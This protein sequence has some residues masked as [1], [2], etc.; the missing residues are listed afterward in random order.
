MIIL[1]PTQQLKDPKHPVYGMVVSSSIPRPGPDY[2][3]MPNKQ[4]HSPCSTCFDRP[5]WAV[6]DWIL[7]INDRSKLGARCGHIGGATLKKAV[8]AFARVVEEGGMP[9]EHPPA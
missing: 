2:I 5:C 1:N 9:I 8:L 4:T 7:R 3:A 6:P